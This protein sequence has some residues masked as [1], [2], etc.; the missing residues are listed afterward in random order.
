MPTR[1]TASELAPA[2]GWLKSSYSDAGSNCAETA[3]LTPTGI[4]VRAS[5]SRD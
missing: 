5:G 2:Q 3:H 1:P 4:A